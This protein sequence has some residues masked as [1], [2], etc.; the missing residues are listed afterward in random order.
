MSERDRRIELFGRVIGELDRELD[1]ALLG[2]QA[3]EGDGS[4]FF[5]EGRRE[6]CREVGLCFADDLSNELPAEGVRASLYVGASV[7]ELCP[8]V[9]ESVV[10]GRRVHWSNLPGAELEELDRALRVVGERCGVELPRPRADALDG[11]AD[12]SCDHLWCVSVLTDPDAF[13]ALHD[14]LYRRGGGPLATGRGD[15]RLERAQAE[16]WA[17]RWFARCAWDCVW[18]T[19]DEELELL[20]PWLET[21]GWRLERPARFRTTALVGDRARHCRIR[22]R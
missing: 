8:I 9:C 7:A 20:L 21:N 16:D 19:T 10:L 3:C 1:W 14:R 15:A 17:R 2:R 4:T 13:P 18:T 11:L 12:S 5:D 22:R 6:R